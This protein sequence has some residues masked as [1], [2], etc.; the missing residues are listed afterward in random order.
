MLDLSQ[1][2]KSWTLFL[3]RD[4]VINHEKKTYV[5]NPEEFKFYDG[6]LEALKKFNKIFSHI[7]IVTNQRGVGRKLMTE[8]DLVNI[9]DV[10]MDEI[11]GA[12]GRIDKI[13]YC[14]AIDNK[15][16]NR[17]P[18]PGMALEAMKDHPLISKQHSIMVGNNMSDMEFGKNA[19]LHTVLLT[20][21]GTSVQLPHPLVD[22]QYNSL[23]DFANA[24][25]KPS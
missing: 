10:M 7:L 14:T 17:K 15:H 18:N 8:D 22:L 3:D 2:N 20:T 16:P 11:K 9:H 12:G 23:I 25:S 21:T 5:F 13:Y 19:G 1:V 4:G 24:L 6:V